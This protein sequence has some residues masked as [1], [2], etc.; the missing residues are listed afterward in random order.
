[1]S[2]N[3]VIGNRGAIP[4]YLPEDFKWIKQCTSGHVLVMG[5][6]TYE[7]IGR[8]LPNRE[9]F[10]LTHQEVEIPG[11]TI[12]HN[13]AD[14]KHYPT[15]KDIWI[16]GGSEIYRMALPYCAELYL[17]IVQKEVEGD[18]YFPDFEPPFIPQETLRDEADFKII[19]YINPKPKAL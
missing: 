15:E 9:T 18:T 14:L 2:L 17:T 6:K 19:R 5:R 12:I 16:F 3:G 11:V 10:V 8:P 13:L 1:M 7:S 4:W